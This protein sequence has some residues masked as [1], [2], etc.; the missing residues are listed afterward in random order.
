MVIGLMGG[1]GCGKSTVMDYLEKQYNAYIIQ[2]DYVAKEVMTPGFDVFKKIKEIFPEVIE[3][4]AIDNNKLAAIVFSDKSKLELLN[5]I[6]HPGTIKEIENRINNC[7]NKLIIV[8]SAILLGSGIE[9]YCDELWFCY[10][11][12]DER[13]RRLIKNRNYSLEKAEQIISNQPYDE[14]YNRFADEFIDNTDSIEKTKEQIDYIMQ[15]KECS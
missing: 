12:Y 5:S 7:N 15:D 8:E 6:V 9:K 13:I 3:N 14:E 10:C 2:S 1:V 11:E 4:N